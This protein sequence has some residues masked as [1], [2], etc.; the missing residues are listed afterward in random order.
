MQCGEFETELAN[1]EQYSDAS[2]ALEEHRSAC[3]PCAALVSDFNVITAQARHLVAANEP[4]DRVWQQLQARMEKSG[5]ITDTVEKPRRVWSPA[6]AFGWLPRFSMGFAYAS[7]FSIA[8][9]VV[10]VY[11]LLGPR[12][13]PPTLPQAPN[14][15]FAQAFEKA[16][17]ATRAT[18]QS[19]LHQIDNSIEQLKTFLAAHPDDPF[20]REQL[21]SAYQQK[22]R[23]WE[24]LVQWQDEQSLPEGISASSK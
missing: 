5:L 17:P 16:A 9:G 14:P 10:Y 22:S 8:V 13:A 3:W 15:P 23:L 2:P 18:Y 21:Y 11:S 7:V 1:L 12:V 4:S 6:A 24:D 19:N 20:A